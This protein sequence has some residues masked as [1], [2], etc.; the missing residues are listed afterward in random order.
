MKMNKHLNVK[1]LLWLCST[2]LVLQF[3]ITSC[4]EVIANET[5]Y[6]FTGEMV[7]DYLQNRSEKF[8]DFIEVLQRAEIYDLLSTYGTYTCFAPTNTAMNSYLQSRGLTSVSQMTRSECDTL[9]YSHLIKVTYFTTDM[10]DGVISTTNMNDRYLSLTCD[11]SKDDQK[12][13]RYLINM[14]S[15]IINRDDSVEN[16]VV[17]TINHVLTSSNDL[18]PTILEKNPTI[19]LFCQAMKLTGLDVLTSKYMDPTY[20]CSNDSVE[21]GILYHTGNEWETGYFMKARKF[22]YT[23]FVETDSVFAQKQNIRTI[24]ELKAYAK[25][26]YDLTYPKDAGLYDQDWTNRKNPLNRFIAYHFLDRLGNYYGLTISGDVKR[27]MQVSSVMD[28]TDTYETMCP[29]T[30]VQ[31]S[32]PSDG[33]YL[34]RTRIGAKF[35]VRGVKI[36]PSDSLALNG[37]YH[38]ID[39]ILTY[40]PETKDVVFNCRF[41]FDATTLSSDFMSSG[42]RGRAGTA[43]CTAFK[44]GAVKDWSFSD[45][46]FVSVRNRHTEFDSYQGDEVVLLGQ[47][48]FTFKLPPVPEGTYEI[49]LGYCAMSTRGVIQTIFERRSIGSWIKSP[50]GIPLDLRVNALNNAIGWVTDAS[51]KETNM[52]ND[53]AMHNRGYMKGPD[54]IMKNGNPSFRNSSATFRCILTTRYLSA[55]EDNYLHIRQVLDN[56]KAEFAFDYIELCPKSV[57]DNGEDTH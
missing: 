21:L 34:N 40:S 45:K 54:S 46:T 30:V 51:N 13:V 5:F 1:H 20:S 52:A 36:A 43:T 19:T 22:M 38:Y 17:H 42:A 6:T 8:S 55:D 4:K 41:R 33:L 11:T 16:G 31:V 25:S 57:Y 10:N 39:D 9:A 44:D 47:Y 26:V 29:H 23:A 50:C 18:L 35:P 12:N 2:F 15:Q 56:P 14:N 7:T 53:K 49:R 28:A 24:A 3:S 48:D 37:V 32:Y 27:L